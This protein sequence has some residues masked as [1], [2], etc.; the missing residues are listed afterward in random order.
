MDR[1]GGLKHTRSSQDKSAFRR[2]KWGGP[3]RGTKAQSERVITH[4]PKIRE[5][6]KGGYEQDRSIR[7]K[8]LSRPVKGPKEF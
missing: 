8:I 4:G 1:A 3:N 5:Y 6:R 2:D 7:P